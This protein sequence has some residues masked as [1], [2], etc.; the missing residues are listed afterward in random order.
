YSDAAEG[1]PAPKVT[2]AIA[3]E[4]EA[5]V[6]TVTDEGI[7]IP[8]AHL[9]RI[10]ERFYRVDRARSRA[11]GGTGL[12]LSIVRHV[13]MNHG[14]TVDVASRLGEGSVFTVRLPRWA[15]R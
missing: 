3:V 10:F 15:P 13:A 8:E 11:T 6:M 1:T 5:V 2:V 4:G 12:G 14:G 7:G 9:D